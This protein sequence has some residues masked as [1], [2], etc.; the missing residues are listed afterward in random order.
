MNPV[1]LKKHQS[2]SKSAGESLAPVS[3]GAAGAGDAL[4]SGSVNGRGAPQK[5]G[6]AVA[7]FPAAGAHVV[8][9]WWPR[10]P[11]VKFAAAE[12]IWK[13]WAPLK[14]KVFMWLVV[15]NRLWTAARR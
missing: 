1:D 11:P 12:P 14:V 4:D 9:T 3:A 8:G 15:K 2:K 6:V 7:G 13:A 5:A 10:S